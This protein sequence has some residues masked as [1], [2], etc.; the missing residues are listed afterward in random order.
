MEYFAILIWLYIV[1]ILQSMTNCSKDFN[2]WNKIKKETNDKILPEKF[3]FY[4]RE[5]WWC[6]IG[7]NIGIEA[8]GKQEYFER[9]VLIIKVFNKEMIWVLPVTSTIKNSP[10]YHKFRSDSGK[11]RSIMI[12]QLRV[13]SAKR[14]RRKIEQMGEEDYKETRRSL[15]DIIKAKPRQKTGNLGGRSQ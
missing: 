15:L 12:T 8:N 10:F 2:K 9:P 4:E 7:K 14:L 13:I 3:F 5:I 6:S 1:V 11:M